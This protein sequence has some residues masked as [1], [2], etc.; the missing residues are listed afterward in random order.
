MKNQIKAILLHL[1]H[2][3]W[4]PVDAELRL[5]E[6]L[7]RKATDAAVAKGMNLLLVDVG[8]GVVFPSHPELAIKGS[9]SPDKLKAEI[10]RLRGMG[11]EVVPKL[12]FSATHD[13]WL[14][15]YSHMVST[16]AYYQV[17]KDVIA[18]VAE[19]FGRPRFF[20]LGWDEETANHQSRYDYVVVRGPEL[21][22]HDF[23]YTVACCE[24]AGVRPWVWSDYGWHHP[25]Y[26][27][28]CPKG[29][30]QSNWYYDEALGGMS[31]DK[32]KNRYWDILQLFLDLEK[33]GFDQV[34]CGSNWRSGAHRA[35]KLPTNESIIPL[36]RFCR[37]RIRPE[38]LKGFLMA[39][40]ASLN[41]EQNLKFNLDGLD[42]FVRALG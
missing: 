14:G 15:E 30:L 23:L 6:D 11:L 16:K 25:D 21:W 19:I 20:H 22:W 36:V 3:M 34:P 2:N 37:E 40:W 12:N 28:R 1:G 35:K 38:R 17:V 32:E 9:W 5:R 8:E 27:T 29:V 4:Q 42:L 10:A 39:P 13:E 26:V 41:T 18:D 7:W 33:A 31:L 24:K